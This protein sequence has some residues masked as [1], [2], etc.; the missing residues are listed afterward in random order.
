MK[1]RYLVALEVLLSVALLAG[2]VGAV[3]VALDRRGPTLQRPATVAWRHP[4]C[5]DP[6]VEFGTYPDGQTQYACPDVDPPPTLP[7]PPKVGLKVES[8]TV[9]VWCPPPK[10]WRLAIAGRTAR[11]HIQ[12]HWGCHPPEERA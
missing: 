9:R 4:T 10:I 8:H 3:L 11:G 6:G 2:A 7:D 12:W 5:A 1:T